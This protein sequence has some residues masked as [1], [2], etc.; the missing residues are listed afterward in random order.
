MLEK[1]HLKTDGRGPVLIMI[2]R[3]M[4]DG[5]KL[6]NLSTI[7]HW[8]GEY[9][10]MPGISSKAFNLLKSKYTRC[11]SSIYKDRRCDERRIK[12]VADWVSSKPTFHLAI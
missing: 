11:A 1:K 4:L 12:L 10:L 8:H 7:Y 5:S 6:P 2:I 3:N 9:S